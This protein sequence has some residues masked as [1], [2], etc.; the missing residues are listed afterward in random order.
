VLKP[1]WSAIVEKLFKKLMVVNSVRG[2]EMVDRIGD[3]L[4]SDQRLDRKDAY[5][6]H[7]RRVL[8]SCV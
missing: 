8:I 1:S 6:G 2:D 4:C 3:N 5:E 7:S